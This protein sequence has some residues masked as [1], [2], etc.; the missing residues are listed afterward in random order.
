LSI[1]SEKC[2]TRKLKF[3]ILFNLAIIGHS[4]LQGKGPQ[5]MTKGM[6]LYNSHQIQIQQHIYK[7]Q[8]HK[9]QSS[10]KGHTKFTQFIQSSKL[11]QN[12]ISNTLTLGGAVVKYLP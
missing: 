4:C 5:Y 1:I 11:A 9:V 10:H 7:F 2:M 12:S 8:V 3:Y 6:P